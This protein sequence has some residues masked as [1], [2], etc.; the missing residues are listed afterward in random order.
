[1]EHS[2]HETCVIALLIGGVYLVARR[3]IKVHAPVSMI[4]TVF[5]LSLL[6]EGGD[7]TGALALVMSGGVFIGA[8]FMATDYATTPTTPLGKV[9]FGVGAGAITVLIRTFGSYP[10]GVSFAILLMNT[11]T[12]YIDKLTERKPFGGDV[13]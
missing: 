12:P 13:E 6:V 5:L 7:L 11:V 10:E 2:L 8:I 3:V 1:M 4:L 9:I